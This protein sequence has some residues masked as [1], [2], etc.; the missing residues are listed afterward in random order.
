MLIASSAVPAQTAAPTLPPVVDTSNLLQISFSLLLVLAV[1]IVLAWLLRRMNLTQQGTGNLLKI[2]GS[3]ALGQRERAVLIEVGDTWLLV[4][5]GPGQIRTLHTLTK[6]ENWQAD[7][8][9]PVSKKFSQ[10]LSAI[11]K[12]RQSNRTR[13]AS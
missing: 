3:V 6:N 8:T 11:L 1:I 4:G 9:A 12:H 2:I 10:Q 13:N 7:V 5:V